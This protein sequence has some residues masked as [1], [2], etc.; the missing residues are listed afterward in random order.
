[1][2]RYAR[3][4]RLI[5]CLVSLLG[6]KFTYHSKQHSKHKNYELHFVERRLYLRTVNDQRQH[7]QDPN[8]IPA[9]CAKDVQTLGYKWFAHGSPVSSLVH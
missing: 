8:T 1:M 7:Q 9:H 5:D 2:L 4:R 6:S 3:G